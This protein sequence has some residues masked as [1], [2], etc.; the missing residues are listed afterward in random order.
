MPAHACIGLKHL[1]DQKI[2][3]LIFLVKKC[4]RARARTRVHWSKTFIWSKKMFLISLVKRVFDARV[5]AHEC[6]CAQAFIDRQLDRTSSISYQIII[7]EIFFYRKETGDRI[8]P[9]Y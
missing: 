8:H 5:R 4:W 7:L 6:T 9:S 3:F 2:F 1:F